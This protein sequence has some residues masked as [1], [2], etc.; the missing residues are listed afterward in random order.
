MDLV[1]LSLPGV[2]RFSLT[3][4]RLLLL[5]E[6][7]EVEEALTRALRERG[8]TCRVLH[9]RGVTDAAEL[10]RRVQAEL[11]AAGG[12]F[13]GV[14]DAVELEPAGYFLATG[15]AG[16]WRR[17]QET[18]A[19]WLGTSKALYPVFKAATDRSTC[20]LALT[21]MG[22]DFG[23]LGDGGNVLGGSLCGFLKGLKQ[24]LPALVA[25][26]VDFDASLD[27]GRAVESALE[28]LEDGSDRVE[29]GYFCG[30]RF[31]VGMRRASFP[32]EDEVRRAIDP[33]WVLLFSGGGRGAVFE[34][35]K[36]VAR[37]G[38]R[39]ILS[40]RTPPPS[41]GE[42]YL[43]LG[44]EAFDA[45]RVEEMRRQKR[46]QPGLTPVK[47]AEGFDERVRGR[48]LFK[49]LAEVFALGLPIQYEVCDV[50]RADQVRDVTDRVR[51]LYGRIDGI[52]HGATVEA[53]KSLPDKTSAGVEPTLAAKALG[54][55]HLLEA[56]QGDEL[57]L[58]MCFGSEP[59]RFGNRGQSDYCAANDLMAKC[60]MAFAHRARPSTRCVTLDWTAWEQV[61]A[62]ARKRAMVESTGVSFISPSE[63]IFWFI[64]EF[65]L[66]GSER[67]VAIF[68]ERLFREWPF[69]GSSA[70]GPEGI[71]RFDDRGLPLVPS[72]HPMV[73]RMLR[74]SDVECV[75]A[76]T[77]DLSRD[78]FLNQHQLYGVPILPGTFG[79]EMMAEGAGLLRPGLTVLR[80]EKLE[81][82]VP[83]KLF[84]GQPVQVEVHARLLKSQGAEVWVEVEM[85]SSLK[86]GQSDVVQAPVHHRGVF[87]L[88]PAPYFPP[89]SGTLP[90]ALPGARARSIFHLAK[91]PVY[92]GPIFCCA[93]WVFVGKGTVEG[94]IRAPR[95]HDLFAQITSPLFA[96]D[97]LLMDAA[98]Q[99]AANWDGHHQK[100]VSVPMGVASLRRGRLRRLG[101]SA[102]VRARPVS[103]SG[104]D[105]FYDID[106]R[107]DDG[108][109]LLQ[110]E[111][112][113][114]R[115]LDANRRE[116]L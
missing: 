15:P 57:Q 4:K 3:K 101:E 24:E 22:G 10:E 90:E 31:G 61:G 105:T 65:M 77:L 33:A 80:G 48:E 98:F 2:T 87:V 28:E 66:G 44:D 88:G 8:A 93:E 17:A 1:P 73:D 100:L 95:Q 82:G 35:A 38:A 70:E 27:S 56:T 42:E 29:V 41:G 5:V 40:G 81:I 12:G 26:V 7:P 53:S 49:N 67:E 104:L 46:I 18:S 62:A 102:H 109:M 112:L 30:R 72:D 54:L 6:R 47:F 107:G 111:R 92:L 23:F 34:V 9:L 108:G 52:V 110:I 76:R 43:S 37:L 79:F 106:V 50:T 13:D 83:L 69:L 60:A 74:A 20:Y 94:I 11:A 89:S 64:N 39:V 114:L 75:S 84:R 96:F 25:K 55:I 115:R 59:G 16:F 85:R 103:V 58:V 68:E 91:D 14:I 63:G 113:G 19:R 97:P 36:A 32:E 21:A 51:G 45:Y 99:V 116:T 86:L 78:P 71:R